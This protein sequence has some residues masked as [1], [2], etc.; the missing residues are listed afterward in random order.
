M[1]RVPLPHLP[2][3]SRRTACDRLDPLLPLPFIYRS[4]KFKHESPHPQHNR[5]AGHT[6]DDDEVPDSGAG[7]GAAAGGG[8]GGGGSILVDSVQCVGRCARSCVPFG[9]PPPL[10]HASLACHPHT[11]GHALQEGGGAAPLRLR[12]HRRLGPG[13]DH[14]STSTTTTNNKK[15]ATVVG[16]PCGGKGQPEASSSSSSSSSSSTNASVAAAVAAA[17]RAGAA[18]AAL[19]G[20]HCKLQWV[21]TVAPTQ[22]V[23]GRVVC[24]GWMCVCCVRGCDVTMMSGSVR[25]CDGRREGA[26]SPISI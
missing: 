22:A 18:A 14:S 7:R 9:C 6:Y 10:Q 24:C 13:D 1:L 11:P 21:W 20:V 8:G 4:P 17:Q 2:N 23:R 3:R 25:G 12:H 16:T 5:T 15:V 26:H 19:K